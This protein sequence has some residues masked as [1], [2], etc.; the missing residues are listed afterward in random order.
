M[1]TATHTLQ[2]TLAATCL[3]HRR[4]SLPAAL[5]ASCVLDTTYTRIP[6][7]T[8]TNTHQTDTRHRAVSQRSFALL[9]T[10][11]ERRLR[12]VHLRRQQASHHIIS[13]RIHPPATCLRK[14]L[15]ARST[16][17]HSLAHHS[18]LRLLVS[19]RLPTDHQST[20]V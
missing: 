18:T 17:T 2:G 9:L 5:L 8:Y 20:S 10:V 4:R 19:D 16:R 12:H 6:C 13:H 15:P 14:C 7:E 11:C 3:Y 1:H